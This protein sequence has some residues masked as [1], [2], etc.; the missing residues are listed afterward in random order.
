MGLKTQD[1]IFLGKD[2]RPAVSLYAREKLIQG[3]GGIIKY[4]IY[5][6]SPSLPQHVQVLVLTGNPAHRPP[7]VDFANLITKKLSLLI[8]AHVITVIFL[9]FFCNNVFFSIELRTRI[10]LTLIVLGGGRGKIESCDAKMSE[11]FQIK[12]T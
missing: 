6:P 2:F 11:K 9:Y 10:F 8:C 5:T 7:L 12:F 1:F 3:W 4:T